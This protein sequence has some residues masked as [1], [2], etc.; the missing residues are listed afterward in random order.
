MKHT[1]IKR[2]GFAAAALLASAGALSAAPAISRLSPP[3]ALFT[4]GDAGAPYTARFL[5]GQRFDL[6]ATVRPSAG[7]T[8]NQVEF[9]VDGVPVGIAP[10]LA[11]TSLV[12]TGLLASLPAGSAVA[13]V[14][15]Y[16]NLV[17]G[18]HTFTATAT[19]SD[20]TTTTVTGNFEIVATTAQ[21]KKAK[22]IIVL[23]GDGVGASHRTAARIMLSG[24][25]QGKANAPLATD[26]M[27]FTGMVQT[28]SLNTSSSIRHTFG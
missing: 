28:A 24:Y 15:G 22:N 6:Q 13:S 18:V 1:H 25:A 3:S 12:T 5:T 19:Q 9:K 20:F 16:S 17:A 14:R 21:G 26:K 27:P 4:F 10:G 23:I 8:I 2:A 7:L 11:N